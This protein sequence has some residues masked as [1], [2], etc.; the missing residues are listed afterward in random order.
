VTV[1]LKGSA[2]EKIGLIFCCIVGSNKNEFTL[3]GLTPKAERRSSTFDRKKPYLDFIAFHLSVQVH[4]HARV[5]AG[6]SFLS[7]AFRS[8]SIR[9]LTSACTNLKLDFIARQ[10][11]LH[12]R[13][14]LHKREHIL[15]GVGYT[16][17]QFCAAMRLH[18][19]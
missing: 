4:E 9:D 19:R 8:V 17:R 2:S 6:H 18:L 12:T 15:H 7:Y 3:F 14:L 10:R 16:F 13:V 1:W 5:E 11:H